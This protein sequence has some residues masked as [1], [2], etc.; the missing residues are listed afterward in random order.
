[1]NILYPELLE[2]QLDIIDTWLNYFINLER[3]DKYVEGVLVGS[4]LLFM[5]SY[6]PINV[7]IARNARKKNDG[8]YVFTNKKLWFIFYLWFFDDENN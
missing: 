8:F 2:V 3:I 7:S 5:S 6:T 4:C 1:M